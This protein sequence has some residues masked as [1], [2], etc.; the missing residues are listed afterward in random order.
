MAGSKHIPH[1]AVVLAQIDA[2][3]IAGDDTRRILAAVLQHRQAV[4]DGLIDIILTDYTDNAAHICYLTS[5]PGCVKYSLSAAEDAESLSYRCMQARGQKLVHMT[6]HGL[7]QTDNHRLP[8]TVGLNQWCQFHQHH[9]Q[10][11]YQAPSR[12][13][14]YH[15]QYPVREPQARFFQQACQQ[16]INHHPTSNT[17][18]NNPTKTAA[19]RSDG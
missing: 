9:H 5:S 14:E 6:E 13:T 1:Q 15:P 4:V 12:Q 11:H 8:P 16:I 17:A 19:T 2:A 10:P 7:Q 3:V 18:T